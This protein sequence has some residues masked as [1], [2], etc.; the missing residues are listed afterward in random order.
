MAATADVPVAT[1]K[2][3]LRQGLLH[4]GHPTAANQARY[5]ASHVRRLRLIRVLREIGELGVEDIAHVVQA[6]DEPNRSLHDVLG[7]AHRAIGR[8]DAADADD[9]GED[10]AVQRMLEDLGWQVPRDAPGRTEL[11]RALRALRAFGWDADA[12]VFLPYARAIEPIAATE[13]G[14]VPAETSRDEAV[15]FIVV[16]TVVFEAALGALRRL[17]QEHHSARRFGA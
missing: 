10:V 11:A 8:R 15:H 16:G 17:A 1:I 5:D 9:G 12:D 7:A 3:Y 2:Y 14:S 13:V 6:I 4:A